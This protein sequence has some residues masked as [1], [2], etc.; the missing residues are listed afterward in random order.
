MHIGMMRQKRETLRK[1]RQRKR[2]GRIGL[3]YGRVVCAG[4]M[5]SLGFGH[6]GFGCGKPRLYGVVY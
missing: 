3:L 4:V 5:A 2:Q 6:E 1:V